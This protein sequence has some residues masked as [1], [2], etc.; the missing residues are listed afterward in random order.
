MREI[1]LMCIFG[2]GFC[3]LG[4][5]A[6]LSTCFKLVSFFG[7]FFRPEDGDEIFLRSAG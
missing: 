2:A 5:K 3:L 6:L 4:Y 1:T 7:L